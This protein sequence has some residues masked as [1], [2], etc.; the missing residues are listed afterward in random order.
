MTYLSQLKT[1]DYTRINVNDK[2]ACFII[3]IHLSP[4]KQSNKCLADPIIFG[5]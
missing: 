4:Q 1:V 5:G 2:I 3:I